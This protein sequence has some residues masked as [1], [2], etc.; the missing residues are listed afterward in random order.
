[1]KQAFIVWRDGDQLFFDKRDRYRTETRR[2]YFSSLEQANKF[3]ADKAD[4][5]I[6]LDVDSPNGVAP[7][8]REMDRLK[9]LES[10][11]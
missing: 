11:A 6:T 3:F 10:A 8:K 7:T 1:M 4:G 2:I 5:W 9:T